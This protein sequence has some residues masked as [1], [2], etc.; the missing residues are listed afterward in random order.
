MPVLSEIGCL[1]SVHSF[2]RNLRRSS[3]SR[4]V[5]LWEHHSVIIEG[6]HNVAMS[7]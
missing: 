6:H 4:G 7:L 2:C 3:S 1:G 5:S